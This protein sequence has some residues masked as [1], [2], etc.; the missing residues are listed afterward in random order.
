MGEDAAGEL[1]R[2]LVER[3]GAE[4]VGGNQGKDSRSGIGSAVHVADVNFVERRFADAEYERAFFFEADVGGALDEMGGDSVGNASERSDAAGQ[5]DH[6]VG[7]IGAAGDVGADIG[8]GLLLDFAG[9]TASKNL[10]DEIVAA[11][12]FEFFRHDA[13]RAV[14]GDEVDGFDAVVAVHGEQELAQK[15]CAAGASGR[16]GQVLR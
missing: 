16:N 14:G 3:S 5:H 11:G 1:V 4:V 12:D 15:D 9:G 13:Q 7:R 6:R 8:V 10:A 2:H